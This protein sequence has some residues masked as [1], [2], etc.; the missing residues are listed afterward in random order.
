MSNPQVTLPDFP[1]MF[2]GHCLEPLRVTWPAGA[3]LAALG[4]FNA[5]LEDDRSL[6]LTEGKIENVN[7]AMTK[8]RPVCEWIGRKKTR[9][10][11]QAALDGECYG[12]KTPPQ[13]DP[14]T[15]HP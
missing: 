4:L 1:V 15:P 14:S 11:I 2:C 10:V 13:P 6:V 5:F 3:G 9:E 8:V 12:H 7:A